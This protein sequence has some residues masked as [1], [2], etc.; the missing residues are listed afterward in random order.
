MINHKH[1]FIFL[2]IPKTGGTSI[3]NIFD[4]NYH[5][6]KQHYPL[7]WHKKTHPKIYAEYF[8]FSIVRNPYDKVISEYLWHKNDPLKQFNNK[9]RGLSLVDFLELFFSIDSTF[10]KN[11][12][13]SGWF[14][15]HFETHRIPQTFFLDPISDLDFVIRFENFQEDFDV[16]CDRIKVPRQKLPHTNKTRSNHYTEYYDDETKSIVAEKYAKDIEYFGYKFE[17]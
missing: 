5:A 15:M 10:F 12:K 2:H 17:G 8:K 6:N 9:F 4:K 7:A 13:W 11:K 16:A 1:K 14:P 3:E